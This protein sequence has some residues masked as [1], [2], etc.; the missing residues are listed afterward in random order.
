M[1]ENNNLWDKFDKAV[2]TE[3]LAAD[4]KEAAENG[5]NFREV[6]HGVYEVEV[7]KLELIESKKG[8]PMVTVW[9]KVVDG[10]YKGCLIFMNQVITQGFQI[11]ITNE[12]LRQMTA[13]LDGFNVEFKT[14]KQYGELLMD[15][16]EAVDGKFEFKLDYAEGKKG[17]STYS[18]DEIY[19]LE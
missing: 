8:D 6:P 17:F 5:A 3:G 13:E 19:I 14:Y 4:V 16:R 7:N 2:D 12:I 1:A 15:I 10:E 11:H 18:I 9:F